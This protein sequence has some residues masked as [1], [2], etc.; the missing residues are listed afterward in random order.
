MSFPRTL[1]AQL[2]GLGCQKTGHLTFALPAQSG[3]IQWHVVF[4]T[5][6]LA[7][8][9]IDAGLRYR[10]TIATDFGWK[11]LVAYGGHDSQVAS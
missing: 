10:H 3:P 2:T 5:L 1:G 9:Q 6:G 11:C 7:K 4:R 8:D